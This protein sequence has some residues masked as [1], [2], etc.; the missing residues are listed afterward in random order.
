MSDY[1]RHLENKDGVAWHL[2]YLGR[3][4]II[5]KCLQKVIFVRRGLV[6]SSG[7]KMPKSW[8]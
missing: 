5:F 4:V 1:N 6:Y 2:I 7:T 3:R 8:K